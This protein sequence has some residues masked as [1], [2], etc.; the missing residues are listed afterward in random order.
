V[1][2]FLHTALRIVGLMQALALS[3]WVKKGL[4]CEA[5]HSQL[6]SAAFVNVRSYAYV[7]MM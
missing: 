3:L 6:N 1:I 4:G 2:F 7:F 5:D